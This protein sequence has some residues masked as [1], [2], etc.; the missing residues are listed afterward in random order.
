MDEVRVPPNLLK[1]IRMERGTKASPEADKK[2]MLSRISGVYKWVE[3][4]GT[5]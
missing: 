5:K 1:V 3:D 4:S 2:M